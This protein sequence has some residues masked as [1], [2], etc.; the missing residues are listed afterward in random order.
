MASANMATGGFKIPCDE[1]GEPPFPVVHY[2]SAFDNL[3]DSRRFAAMPRDGDHLKVFDPRNGKERYITVV[4]GFCNGFIG[5]SE[6]LQQRVALV[7]TLTLHSFVAM[8][9]RIVNSNLEESWC[10]I[11]MWQCQVCHQF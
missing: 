9:S 11:A 7:M 1:R 5:G 8:R 2:M 3:L 4:R 6:V 10:V